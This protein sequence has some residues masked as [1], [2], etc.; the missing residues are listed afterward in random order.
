MCGADFPL[1][2]RSM[3]GEGAPLGYEDE[4]VRPPSD[5]PQAA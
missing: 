1:K 5:V 3:L 4:A 2:V